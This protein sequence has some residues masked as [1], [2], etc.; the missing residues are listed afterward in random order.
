VK[1]NRANVN[2]SFFNGAIEI[3]SQTGALGDSKIAERYQ[4]YEYYL[5]SGADVIFVVDRSGSIG[6]GNPLGARTPRNTGS[7]WDYMLKAVTGS[8]KTLNQEVPK[9][10]VGLLSFGTDVLDVGSIVP[11]DGIVPDVPLTNSLVALVD[12]VDPLDPDDDMPKMDL[13]ISATNLSL[14]IAVA[15]SALMEKYYP[16]Q[17]IDSAQTSVTAG[18]QTGGFEWLVA[19]D[20]NHQATDVLF[21][22]GLP[23][24]PS[25]NDRNDTLYPDIIVVISDGVPNAIVTHVRPLPAKW[26]WSAVNSSNSFITPELHDYLIGESKMFRTDPV[27]GGP[28]IVDRGNPSP[29]ASEVPVA[30]R[31]NFCNDVGHT[32]NMYP[33]LSNP[34]DSNEWPNYAICNAT[35]IAT[36][37]KHDT[38]ANITFIAI[39]VGN[40]STDEAQWFE[41]Q[42]ASSYTDTDGTT[43]YYFANVVSY[44]DVEE[45]LLKQFK[46]LTFVKSL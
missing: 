9:P 45:A 30:N 22:N 5:L 16:F 4:R 21:R 24:N 2:S 20:L 39:L 34:V 40:A 37:L 19:Q 31:Y 11:G 18:D 1:V 12:D 43:Q 8:I 29:T 36:K 26:Y 15:G 6:T 28:Q 46:T 14:G 7:E 38:D 27:G 33:Y 41:E 3:Y 44:A 10:Y 42:F 35:M 23:D 25:T 32:P 13:T 17:G